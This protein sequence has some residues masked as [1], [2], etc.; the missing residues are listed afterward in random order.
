[1]A[2]KTKAEAKVPAEETE[3][4]DTES[5]GADIVGKK[6]REAYGKAGHNGDPIAVALKEFTCDDKGK[7]VPANMDEVA[8]A[9]GLTEKLTNWAHLNVGMQ[10]MN[11][12]NALRKLHRAG[13]DVVI[14]NTVIDG[15]PQEEKEAA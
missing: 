5:K 2:R 4:T 14:G 12:G 15:V 6:Y 9:N 1:M 10:R 11:L 8:E 3:S 13:T 7:V